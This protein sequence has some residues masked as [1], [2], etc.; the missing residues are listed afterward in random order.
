MTSSVIVAAAVAFILSTGAGEAGDG[1]PANLFPNPGFDEFA[2]D[3]PEGWTFDSWNQPAMKVR[4]G[5]LEPGRDG[6]GHCLEIYILPGMPYLHVYIPFP[7][8]TVPPACPLI[9]SAN[10][11]IYRGFIYK[12]LS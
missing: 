6:K 3:V 11:Y 9:Y 4:V 8:T 10:N 5:K 12:F 7:S 2:G 1:T